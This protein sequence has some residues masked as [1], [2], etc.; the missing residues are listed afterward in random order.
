MQPRLAGNQFPAFCLFRSAHKR[1]FVG[2]FPT[3]RKTYVSRIV[4][5]GMY[6]QY[7]SIAF[8][9]LLERA[10]SLFICMKFRIFIIYSCPLCKQKNRPELLHG[11]ENSLLCIFLWERNLFCYCVPALAFSKERYNQ[12]LAFTTLSIWLH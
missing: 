6:V 8:R 9:I 5:Y 10:I 11:T 4:K 1:I 2:L 7:G 3:I 12:T